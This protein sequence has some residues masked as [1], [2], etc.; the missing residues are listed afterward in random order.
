MSGVANQL[1]AK[2]YIFYDV[3]V[4]VHI[5]HMATQTTHEPRSLILRLARF[6]VNVTP[7]TIIDIQQ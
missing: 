4:K 1:E 3:T 7:N 5:I 2:I 6:I